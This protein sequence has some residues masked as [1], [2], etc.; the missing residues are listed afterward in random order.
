MKKS[1]EAE[2]SSIAK[3]NNNKE[4][5]RAQAANNSSDDIYIEVLQNFLS[6]IEE[7]VNNYNT[8]VNS[9]VLSAYNLP[10]D[11]LEMF[12]DIP[13]RRGGFCLVSPIKIAVFFDEDPQII[14]VIG[15][16]RKVGGEESGSPRTTQLFKISFSKTGKDYKYKDNTGG[17]ID[18]YDIV[19]IIVKWITA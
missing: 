9:E 12:L 16:S 7:A 4:R 11:F 6:V 3:S 10:K 17:V 14:T 1:F 19:S 2:I 13:G 8:A 15:K 5:Q 18:P